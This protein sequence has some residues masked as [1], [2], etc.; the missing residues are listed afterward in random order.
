MRTITIHVFDKH[1]SQSM[2]NTI[3]IDGIKPIVIEDQVVQFF[4]SVP[5]RKWYYEVETFDE[6][7]GEEKDLLKRLDLEIS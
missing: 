4:N 3:R 5:Y 7:T 2:S 6:L 1:S